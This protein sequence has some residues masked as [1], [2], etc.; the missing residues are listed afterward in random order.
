MTLWHFPQM[1]SN[2]KSS[3]SL[4]AILFAVSE[5]ESKGSLGLARVEQEIRLAVEYLEPLL[6]TV[7]QILGRVALADPGPNQLRRLWANANQSH[8]NVLHVS[9]YRASDRAG[10]SARRLGVNQPLPMP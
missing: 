9:R 8:G 3:A 6:P 4:S 7:N 2:W 1:K 5:D 10:R